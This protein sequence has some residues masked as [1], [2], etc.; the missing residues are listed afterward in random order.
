MAEPRVRR[1]VVKFP[2]KSLAPKIARPSLSSARS[3]GSL[4]APEKSALAP[5]VL[6]DSGLALYLRPGAVV[7]MVFEI[8]R[9]LSRPFSGRFR[10]ALWRFRSF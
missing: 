4:E 9:H 8:S 7:R 1:E 6:K 10:G 5:H 3:N 2:P